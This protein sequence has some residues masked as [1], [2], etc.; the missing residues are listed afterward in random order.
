MKRYLGVAQTKSGLQGCLLEDT[1]DG[2]GEPR[3]LYVDLSAGSTDLL[4]TPA[5]I[6]W[7]C[8][9]PEHCSGRSSDPT[10]DLHIRSHQVVELLRIADRL[11]GRGF[12]AAHLTAWLAWRDSWGYF[13]LDDQRLA[14]DWLEH[15]ARLRTTTSHR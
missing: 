3:P 5:G 2:F 10:R 8:P 4:H 6:A 12:R 15:L 1:S 13:P 14:W 7:A 9:P 11:Q